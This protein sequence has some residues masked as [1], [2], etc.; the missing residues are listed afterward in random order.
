MEKKSLLRILALPFSVIAALIAVVLFVIKV[1]TFWSTI[2]TWPSTLFNW[3]L[4]NSTDLLIAGLII[5]YGASFLYFLTL[6]AGSLNSAKEYFWY[7][8]SWPISKAVDDLISNKHVNTYDSKRIHKFSL[9]FIWTGIIVFTAGA[10]SFSNYHNL[11]GACFIVYGFITL[12]VSEII[13][14]KKWG[15]KCSEFIAA[16]MIV[17]VP[18][19]LDYFIFGWKK[20]WICGTIV[21]IIIFFVIREKIK[22]RRR[23]KKY[24]EESEKIRI[25]TSAKIAEEERKISDLKRL[26][27]GHLLEGYLTRARKAEGE[28][29][30]LYLKTYSILKSQGKLISKE[31]IKEVLKKIKFVDCAIDDSFFNLIL[32]EL[33]N[34]FKKEIFLTNTVQVLND[35]LPILFRHHPNKKEAIKALTLIKDSDFY[36]ELRK[37]FRLKEFGG[38]MNIMAFS[39]EKERDDEEWLVYLIQRME[40]FINL[41]FDCSKKVWE[42]E[43]SKE[44]LSY[45]KTLKRKFE[46]KGVQVKFPDFE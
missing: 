20:P 5:F 35:N 27:L 19:Y 39:Y 7:K 37:E 28:D 26:S 45:L 2:V 18:Y 22:D 34:D 23:D 46:N 17:A 30:L 12:V 11:L 4:S 31:E 44:I 43:S 3:S 15:D 40:S 25:E 13:F 33:E 24:E 10:F 14:F 29:K 32:A 6:P 8:P 42:K 16:P 1:V 36:H 41:A 38:V 9:Y 21:V